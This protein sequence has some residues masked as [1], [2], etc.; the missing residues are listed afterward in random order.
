MVPQCLGVPLNTN[1]AQCHVRIGINQV[2][3][4]SEKLKA[5]ENCVIWWLN[6]MLIKT[7]IGCHSPMAIEKF[8]VGN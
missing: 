5:I 3:L 4:P 7:M 2:G 1:V 8:L 6:P